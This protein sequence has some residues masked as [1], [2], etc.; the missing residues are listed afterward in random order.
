M[1]PI[2]PYGIIAS[3]GL[4]KEAKDNKNMADN[5]STR[6]FLVVFLE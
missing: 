6:I 1:G 2:P 4:V 3:P 5:P